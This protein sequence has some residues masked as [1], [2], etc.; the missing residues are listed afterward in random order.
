[1]LIFTVGYIIGILWGLYF[2]INMVFFYA[3]SVICTILLKKFNKNIPKQLLIIIIVSFTI[4]NI[5]VNLKNNKYNQIY[6][7]FDNKEVAVNAVIVSDIK[8]SKYDYSCKI[9]VNSINNKRFNNLYLNL[10]IRKTREK[11]LEYGDLIRVNGTFKIPNTRRN[12]KGFDYREYLKSK[13][14]YG[15]IKTRFEKIQVLDKN[16][17]NFLFSMSNSVKNKMIEKQNA[18]LPEDASS[19]INGILLGYKE[20]MSDEMIESFKGSSLSHI[21]AVSRVTCCLYNVDTKKYI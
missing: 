6:K 1:L 2:K 3:I 5:Y 20:D 12:Y 7:L 4:S 13:N 15:I 9:K 18:A 21:L 17:A 8:E 16:K 10:N 19:L 11:P 14:V